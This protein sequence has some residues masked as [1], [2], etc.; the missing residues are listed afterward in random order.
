MDKMDGINLTRE[1]ILEEKDIEIQNF[2]KPKYG[3]SL[4]KL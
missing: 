3:I 2:E 4:K 1:N